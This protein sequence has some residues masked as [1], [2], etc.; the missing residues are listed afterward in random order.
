[1]QSM[2]RSERLIFTK[3]WPINA[4]ER[5]WRRCTADSPRMRRRTL[6]AL[7]EVYESAYLKFM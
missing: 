5:P 7:E 2:R 1:M 4:V 6:L 3:V